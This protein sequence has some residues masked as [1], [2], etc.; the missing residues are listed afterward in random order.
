[1]HE[2]TEYIICWPLQTFYR[3]I[4]NYQ[5]DV[6]DHRVGPVMRKRTKQLQDLITIILFGAHLTMH[7]MHPNKGLA[8]T[9][10]QV[11]ADIL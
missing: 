11:L 6:G 3:Q 4:A 1:M 9:H 7:L 2:Q 10:S 5:K 8:I